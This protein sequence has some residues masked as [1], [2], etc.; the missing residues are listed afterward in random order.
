MTTRGGIVRHPLGLI[1]LAV[2]TAACSSSMKVST[3]YDRAANFKTYKTYAWIPTP[4]GPEEAPQVRDP[5]IMDAVVHGI[6]SGLASKG[7]TKADSGQPD[8]L[9]AVHGWATSRID[10]AYYG[11]TYS[12][13]PYGYYPTLSPGMADIKEYRD[14][15]LLIDLVDASTKQMVWRG[16]ATDTFQPGAEAKKVSEAIEKTLDEYP[17]PPEKK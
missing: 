9:V 13:S 5:R 2:A 16:T 14:G 12:H 4:P 6:E 10:V 3:E 15:T 8:L 11:Y 1:S 7:L 17:P